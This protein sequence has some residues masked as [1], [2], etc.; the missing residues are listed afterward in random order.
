MQ[1]FLNALQCQKKNENRHDGKKAQLSIFFS[2][3]A[4]SLF[5]PTCVV[6]NWK[7]R[8]DGNGKT[9]IRYYV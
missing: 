4:S 3:R 2:A 1:Q 8:R 5:N 9:T 7:K 6:T